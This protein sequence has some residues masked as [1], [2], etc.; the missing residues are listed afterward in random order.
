M[1]ELLNRKYVSLKTK[2][3]GPPTWFFLHSV[4]FTYPNNPTDQDKKNYYDFFI[5]ISNILPCSICSNSYKKYIF[6][7]DTNLSNFLDSRKNLSYWLYLIH[8]KVNKK[9]NVDPKLIPTYEQVVLKYSKY[10]SINKSTFV[11]NLD[12]RENFDNNNT[13]T[14][15]NI[16]TNLLKN[17]IIIILIIII[18]ILLICLL[19]KK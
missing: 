6:E 3:W 13:N 18:I 2:V 8:N 11:C 17:I 19:K 4:S 10:I 7:N 14:N 1:N 16:N 9:L 5:S 12:I 15:T